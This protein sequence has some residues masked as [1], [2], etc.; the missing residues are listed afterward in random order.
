MYNSGPNR[1]S[2]ICYKSVISI[3]S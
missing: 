1:D 3:I 2:K